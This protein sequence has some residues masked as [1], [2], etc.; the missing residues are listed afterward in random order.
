MYDAEA[1]TLAGGLA[2]AR[3]R[4][5]LIQVCNEETMLCK[6]EAAMV[7]TEVARLL[8]NE[9]TIRRIEGLRK[10]LEASKPTHR[11]EMIRAKIA[12]L[13]ARLGD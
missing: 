3:L 8:Q 13:E 9:E 1:A 12:Q 2:A 7:A 6:G 5:R 4:S 11:A 10:L